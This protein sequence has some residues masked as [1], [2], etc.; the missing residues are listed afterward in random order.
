MRGDVLQ[1][2]A[3]LMLLKAGGLT[4]ELATIVGERAPVTQ[5]RLCGR[6]GRGIGR[7]PGDLGM[8]R[9]RAAS[10]RDVG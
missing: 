5:H 7:E 3:A 1:G 9:R 8:F 2:K 6:N 10:T 4:V